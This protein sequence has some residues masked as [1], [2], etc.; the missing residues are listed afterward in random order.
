MQLVL[1]L[2]LITGCTSS[3][4]SESK[5]AQSQ[6][7]TNTQSTVSINDAKITERSF[8]IE[9]SLSSKAFIQQ[10]DKYVSEYIELGLEQSAPNNTILVTDN[11]H[12][13]MTN[14]R[15]FKNVAAITP[16]ENALNLLKKQSVTNINI[17]KAK[18]T[19]PRLWETKDI[20]SVLLSTLAFILSVLSFG[21]ALYSFSKSR[22]RSVIDDYW[23]RQVIFPKCM[24]VVTELVIEARSEFTKFSHLS[25]FYEKFFLEKSNAIRDNFLLARPLSENIQ[26]E[27]NTLLDNLDDDLNEITSPDQLSGLMSKFGEDIMKLLK[28]LQSKI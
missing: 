24:G 13:T 7:I 1:Q 2:L 22:E 26:E 12:A 14:E 17:N 16:Q 5:S 4:S 8:E 18:G 3:F 28:N 6:E 15:K 9:K 23:M 10:N 19:S 21:W 20:L 25:D 11:P 27:V